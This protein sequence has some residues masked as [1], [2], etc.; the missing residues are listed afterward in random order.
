MPA[1]EQHARALRLALNEVLVS[2]AVRSLVAARIGL[3]AQAQASLHWLQQAP[4]VSANPRRGALTI[5]FDDSCPGRS[6][7]RWLRSPLDGSAVPV[8][9]VRGASAGCAHASPTWVRVQNMTHL[10]LPP[11]EGT[12][13]AFL[14]NPRNPSRLLALTAGHVVG[15]AGTSLRGDNVQLSSPDQLA[16]TGS[17]FDWQPKFGQLPAATQLDA[18]IVEV[19]AEALEPLQLQDSDWP[20]GWSSPFA[21]DVLHLR[22][23]GLVFAGNGA[24]YISCRIALGRQ[25]TVSYVIT[26]GLCWTA[27]PGFRGGD[28]GAPIWNAAEELVAIHAGTTPPGSAQNAIAIPIGRILRWADA[29]VVTRGQRLS[30]TAPPRSGAAL[31]GTPTPLAPGAPPAVSP[32]IDTLAR[33]MWGEARGEPDARQGMGAVAHVVLN[34]VAHRTYWGHDIEA[35]CRKPF[36][37]SCWNA[38]DVNLRKI[39]EVG[40]TNSQFALALQLA[41]QLAAMS[42]LARGNVDPTRGATHY[43]ARSLQ[44]PPRWARGQTPCARLGNHLFYRGVG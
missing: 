18:G 13:G 19:A 43:H 21:D 25:P 38:R 16:L 37:F 8:R 14:R 15:A 2:G 42:D 41:T 26:D 22:T 28:S 24:E 32:E 3:D 6:L 35:V 20:R 40:A 4:V 17:L 23:R 36:Q 33:T 39:I 27:E 34:R 11:L 7:P 1:R 30:P 5:A 12:L 44:P 9:S 10:A 29:E 31:L